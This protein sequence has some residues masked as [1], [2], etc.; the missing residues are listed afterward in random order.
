MSEYLILVT[1]L[2]CPKIVF[3]EVTWLDRPFLLEAGIVF[4][5]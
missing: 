5:I 4:F 3:G 2:E 1:I